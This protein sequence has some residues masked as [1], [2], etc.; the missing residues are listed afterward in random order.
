M[1]KQPISLSRPWRRSSGLL[2][3]VV[4]VGV[5]SG[6]ILRPSPAKTKNEVDPYNTN[7]VQSE[8]YVLEVGGEQIGGVVN[9]QL[10]MGGIPGGRSVGVL[11]CP[12]QSAMVGLRTR[13]GTVVDF[14]QIYCANVYW[15]RR[16]W[17]WSGYPPGPGVGNEQGGAT[18]HDQVCASGYMVVG[19]RAFT[20]ENGKY[21]SDVRIDCA[22]IR[23]EPSMRMRIIEPWPMAYRVFPRELDA[24]DPRDNNFSRRTSQRQGRKSNR[25]PAH[26]YDHDTKV[27]VGYSQASGSDSRQPTFSCDESGATG[28]AYGLGR[29][30]VNRQ[31]VVQALTMY[32]VGTVTMGEA[33]KAPKRGLF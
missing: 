30:G 23:S 9:G 24:S 10:V 19:F 2:V 5:A 31:I 28:I 11:R 32:C 29:W 12:N 18:D 17:T 7:V 16:E 22:R 3:A 15:N 6:Q 27:R 20:R 33:P 4:I 13:V 25:D 8:K 21:L 14:M 1:C 26:R